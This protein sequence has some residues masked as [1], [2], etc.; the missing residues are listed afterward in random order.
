MGDI[1][2]KISPLKR[3]AATD[4]QF[5]RLYLGHL[6][7]MARCKTVRA[8]MLFLVIL[9][10]SQLSG[11][12]SPRRNREAGPGVRVPTEALRGVGLGD[13]RV[14]SRATG[15]L[16][17]LDLIRTHHPLGSHPYWSFWFRCRRSKK[18]HVLRGGLADLQKRHADDKVLDPSAVAA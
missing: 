7:A 1:P 17:G 3:P 2:I 14:R 6:E 16:V 12:H 18:P 13:A 15:E 10:F 8:A 5:T 4:H 11:H 9:R